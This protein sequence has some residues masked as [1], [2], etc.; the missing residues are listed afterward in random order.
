MMIILYSSPAHTFLFLHNLELLI[1]PILSL[2]LLLLV[3]SIFICIKRFYLR[4]VVLIISSGFYFSQIVK[5]ALVRNYPL[6][7]SMTKVQNFVIH[8]C[9]WVIIKKKSI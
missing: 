2:S 3:S 9:W 5:K 1:N 8:H 7:T 4:Q 6:V